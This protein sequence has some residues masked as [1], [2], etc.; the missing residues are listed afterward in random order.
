MSDLLGDVRCERT[1]DGGKCCLLNPVGCAASRRAGF[2][3]AACLW[4]R[5]DPS[6]EP[7][8]PYVSGDDPR[9]PCSVYP[10]WCT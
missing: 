2:G 9:L 8:G 7:A 4:Q 10:R 6:G 3:E 5:L 1:P